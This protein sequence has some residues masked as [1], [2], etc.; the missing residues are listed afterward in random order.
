MT[1]DADG[2]RPRATRDH[3]KKNG[4]NCVEE[5]MKSL[6]LSQ[7]DALSQN[8]YTRKTKTTTG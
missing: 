8:K 3:P 4:W 1:M 5:D 6:D 2:T 7:E